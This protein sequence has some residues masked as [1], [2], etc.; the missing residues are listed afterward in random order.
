MTKLFAQVRQWSTFNTAKK[1][2]SFYNNALWEMTNKHQ[3]D[4]CQHGPKH[5]KEG[6]QQFLNL[7]HENL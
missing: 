3:H 7:C 1:S 5:F 2:M 6:F 4:P